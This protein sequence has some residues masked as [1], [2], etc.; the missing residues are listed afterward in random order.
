MAMASFHTRGSTKL[1]GFHQMTGKRI[2]LTTSLSLESFGGLSSTSEW[3]EDQMQQQTATFWLQHWNWNWI[4]AGWR[5]PTDRRNLKLTSLRTCKRVT[6]F[7]RSLINN[8]K[9]CKSWWRKK[10]LRSIGKK[11]K[12]MFSNNMWVSG[13]IE[14]TPAQWMDFSRHYEGDLSNCSNY[15]E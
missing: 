13:R 15:R 2:K 12:L 14:E 9:Y 1:S 7:H 10:N 8:S 6:S 3:R 4:K 11:A 5:R